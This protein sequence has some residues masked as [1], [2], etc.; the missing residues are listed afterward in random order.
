MK[1]RQTIVGLMIMLAMAG[2]Y[3]RSWE[4]VKVERQDMRLVMRESE[5]EIKTASGIIQVATNHNVG[6]KIF[7]ILGRLVSSENLAPG[8]FQFQVPVHGVYIVKA[9]DLTCKVAV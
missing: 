9:G 1:P 8:V 6:I 2:S 5:V 3:A 7:T 4:T